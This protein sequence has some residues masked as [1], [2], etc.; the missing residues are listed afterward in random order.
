MSVVVAGSINLDRVYRV[1]RI[2][3]PGETVLAKGSAQH[4]GGKGNNQIV[5]AA[6]AGA[7]A[8]FIAAVGDDPDGV[9]LIA[10]LRNDDIRVC[11]R[12]VNAATGTAMIT[13]SSSS[14]NSIVVNPGANGRLVDL[15]D[16]ELS[17]I[18]EAGTL[19]LQLEIPL[20]TVKE[21]ADAAHRAGVR[22]VL[23]AAPVQPLPTGLLANID[24]LIVNEHEARQ[25]VP[26]GTG[27]DLA[28][29]AAK[30]TDLVPSVIVTI[31]SK[32]ALVA[33]HGAETVLVPG[34]PVTAVDTTGAGD[35]FC[36]ALVAA[37]DEQPY[38]G[39][40]AA[41]QFAT[42]AAALSV[43]REGAVPSIPTRKEID[44]ALV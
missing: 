19:L 40:V 3:A 35:T 20:D 6:R 8:T 2:P 7:Q 44:N 9:S 29:L 27:I 15:T 36:G 18:T 30:L 23:N 16:E 4:P 38:G 39:L 31:G 41:A 28:E 24:V 11:A 22:V 17:L 10:G 34:I 14:E 25:L 43:Q 33:E 1:E 12:T 32:G 5:A 42:T 21:A 37:L 13:V 26:T